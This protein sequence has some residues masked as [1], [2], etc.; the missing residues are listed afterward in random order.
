MTSATTLPI[1][2]P[3]AAVGIVVTDERDR[4]ML[5]RRAHNALT[6]AGQ[7][8]LPGGKLDPGETIDDAARRELAEETGVVATTLFRLDVVTEDL[9]W[10]PALHFVTCYRLAAAWSGTPSLLEPHKHIEL[11]WLGA[12]DIKARIATRPD[13]VFGPLRAF[14]EQGG[15][16]DLRRHIH[17]F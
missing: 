13:E 9:H 12:L 10:G 14:V 6:G 4:I 11:L 17:G 15:L 3:R 1:P 7:I 2:S 16:E 8:A 5:I